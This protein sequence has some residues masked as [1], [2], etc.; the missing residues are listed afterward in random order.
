LIYQVTITFLH[1]FY[2]LRHQQ[3]DLNYNKC[4]P[5]PGLSPFHRLFD[6]LY[7]LIRFYYERIKGNEWF[8]QIT[9]ADGI[10]EELWL[11]GAPDTPQDY[12]YL[13]DQGIRAVVNVRAERNDDVEF[14]Q[15]HDIAYLQVWAP[16][17]GVPEVEAIQAAVSWIAGRVEERRPVLVHCAKGRGRSA[18]ILAAYLVKE[19][20]L[21][22]P[23]AA[24]LL[25][26]RRSL[27]KL[28]T[29]HKAQIQRLL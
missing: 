7:P 17:I 12:A 18:V 1:R 24:A 15:E 21:S 10:P 28:E 22:Y 14:Y 20:Y 19:H 16:D 5:D 13:L 3:S 29:R 2:H 4:M 11:G 6:K 27:T 9:P 26:E 25:K 23:Q 8:S